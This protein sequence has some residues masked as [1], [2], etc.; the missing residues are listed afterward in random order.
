MALA[1]RGNAHLCGA[2]EVS[3]GNSKS[4]QRKTKGNPRYFGTLGGVRGYTH[5][6][7]QASDAL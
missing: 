6:E 1:E 4:T 5:D 2:R 3:S 7:P